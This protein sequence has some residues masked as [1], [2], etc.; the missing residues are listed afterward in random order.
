MTAIE[1]VA[2]PADWH[3]AKIK[4]LYDSW[5]GLTP[6]KANAS[7]WGP[8][9][10]W[11]SSKEV[12]SER[13]TG[14]THS[15]T[16]VAV[17][18]TGL[19]VCPPGSVLV[20][21]RSGILAHTLP[22]S[23]TEIP[24]VI[25]QDLKA[26][27]AEEPLMNEWLAFFL[28]SCSHEL[29]A[30]SR[31]DGTTVQSIQYPLLQNTLVPVPQLNERRQILEAIKA[32]FAKEAS[33]VSNFHVS[34]NALERLRQAVLT[35]AC[36]GRLTADWRDTHQDALRIDLSAADTVSKRRKR[37][38]EAPIDL[39][40]PELPDSYAVATIGQAASLIEYGTSQAIGSSGENS[41]PILRMGNIQ[42]GSLDLTDLKYHILDQEIMKL[43]LH[44]GDL[45]F[46]RTNSP[47]LVGKSAVY[48]GKE[49]MS[50][51]SYL[52]RVRFASDVCDPDFA[53]YW[54]NS[55]WGRAWAHLGK[56]DGV[57]QSNIN[58]TKLAAMPLPLPPIDE[59]REIVRRASKLLSTADSLLA[60]IDEGSRAVVRSSQA[61]LARAFRGELLSSP[62]SAVSA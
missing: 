57:S 7:Y 14:S 17:K 51:A 41:V 62:E 56:T 8:G 50:F 33:V 1:D 58:G 45:L 15:V 34:R 3:T 11:V 39:D 16:P 13:L 2:L 40:L 31:R 30:S 29:L 55:A 48:H 26:F 24:V 12:K 47:E 20:V 25:N 27:Y 44:D 9:I 6:S 42:A 38:E 36:T 43:L 60:R 37:A 10:P 59:Q 22:V 23:I 4:D 52:I 35:A 5:G 61:I 46:N 53:N 19:R 54:I 28:R 18:E 32:A 21:V 49:P